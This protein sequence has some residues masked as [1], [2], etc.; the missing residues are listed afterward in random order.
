MTDHDRAY[1]YRRAEVELERAQ[2]AMALPAV[3]A[4]VEMA[5][6]YMAL[7]GSIVARPDH[8]TP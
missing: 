3:R 4:H 6:R 2:Q 7:C 5:E 8:A 1:F